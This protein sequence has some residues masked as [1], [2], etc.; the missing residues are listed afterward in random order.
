MMQRRFV[1]KAIMPFEYDFVKGSKRVPS[2]AIGM[3]V[4][5]ACVAVKDMAVKKARMSNT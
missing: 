3:T 5:I 2:P 4:F 1:D